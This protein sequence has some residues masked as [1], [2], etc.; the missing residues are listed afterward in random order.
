[1]D[2]ALGYENLTQCVLEALEPCHRG[3]PPP[4]QMV[5]VLGELPLVQFELGY[6]DVGAWLRF[7]PIEAVRTGS[8]GEFLWYEG[9]DDFA[10]IPSGQALA[11]RMGA[12][13]WGPFDGEIRV[14]AP[15]PLELSSPYYMT[16]SENDVLDIRWVPGSNGVLTLSLATG[17]RPGDL[18]GSR[19]VHRVYTLE[20]DGSFEI[21]L[22]E[23]GLTDATRSI[24][25]RLTRTVFTE[26][27]VNGRPVKVGIGSR[28]VL[29]V[30]Y[31]PIAGRTWV[32]I[33]SGCAGSA[34][35]GP[36]R[37][38]G[39]LED[40][41]VPM[42]L[43]GCTGS[44]ATSYGFQGEVQVVAPAGT[45]TRVRAD[46]VDDSVSI[47]LLSSCGEPDTCVAGANYG[48]L[49][50]ID[51]INATPN[52]E[53]LTLLLQGELATVAPIVRFDI[54][55][56]P[57]PLPSP[58]FTSTCST[59]PAIPEGHH[60][61]DPTGFAQSCQ[62]PTTAAAFAN[63]TIPPSG[64]LRALSRNPARME[65]RDTCEDTCGLQSGPYEPL[66]FQNWASEPVTR[67][68]VVQVPDEAAIPGQLDLEVDIASPEWVVLPDTCADLPTVEPLSR[69]LHVFL[70]DLADLADDGGHDCEGVYEAV[71]PDGM[72]R[73][74]LAPGETLHARVFEFDIFAPDLVLSVDPECPRS[75]R[76]VMCRDPRGAG[77]ADEITYTNVGVVE[78]ELVLRVDSREALSSSSA[79]LRLE[80][81]IR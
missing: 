26:G 37:Y 50:V 73:V 54:E 8:L 71:G 53:I 74:R 25:A 10:A 69:G 78:E 62:G 6:E 43:P 12:G 33:P 45:R 75:R 4:G 20:D 55:S 58:G 34:P 52:D 79:P 18:P 3:L 17:K 49:E 72:H 30:N 7:G 24:D 48:D 27:T 36:G 14:T 60:A 77:M 35:L 15:D 68:L 28:A 32:P 16:L 59:D 46:T 29:F 80:I 76:P 44:N 38:W 21:P 57:A 1:M 31:L 41:R 66:V 51:H 11:L 42:D 23:L 19:E 70:M 61:V 2:D 39:R 63:V 13:D 56:S 22:R 40:Q 81:S 67:Q 5:E 65:L 47:A 64:T 9:F